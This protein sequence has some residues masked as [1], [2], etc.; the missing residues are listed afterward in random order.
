MTDHGPAT[1]E[2]ALEM[3]Q[4]IPGGM[5]GELNNIE[6]AYGDIIEELEAEGYDG[7]DFDAADLAAAIRA[8]MAAGED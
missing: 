4:H 7:V 3:M 1:I 2:D 6:A 8:A 5:A